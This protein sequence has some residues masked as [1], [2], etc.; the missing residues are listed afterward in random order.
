VEVPAMMTVMGGAPLTAAS[1]P[2]IRRNHTVL[3]ENFAANSI[4]RARDQ[5]NEPGGLV[6]WEEEEEANVNVHRH[7]YTSTKQ[8]D[9]TGPGE[10]SSA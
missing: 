8:A 10:G 5:A 9:A 3:G 4:G 1:A 6:M 7:R 2:A